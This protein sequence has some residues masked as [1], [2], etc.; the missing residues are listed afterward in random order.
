MALGA[1][2]HLKNFHIE[3]LTNE[4]CLKWLAFSVFFFLLVIFYKSHLIEL[5]LHFGVYEISELSFGNC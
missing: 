1:G 2:G 5:G 4:I 3:I